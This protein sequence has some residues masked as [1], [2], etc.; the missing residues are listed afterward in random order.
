MTRARSRLAAIEHRDR[1]P[2][3]EPPGDAQPNDASADDGDARLIADM[4]KLSRQRRL[5]SLE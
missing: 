5:P 1:R 2:A 4:G 3:G